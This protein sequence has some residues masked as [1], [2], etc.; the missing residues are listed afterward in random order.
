MSS[1]ICVKSFYGNNKYQ[2]NAT[3]CDPNNNT[4]CNNTIGAS[5]IITP[6]DPVLSGKINLLV[7]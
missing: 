1:G 7:N 5:G 4:L 6:Q 2:V 3:V